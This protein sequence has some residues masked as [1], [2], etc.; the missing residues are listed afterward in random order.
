MPPDLVEC[1]SDHAYLGY[2]VGFYWLNQRLEVTS[3]LSEARDSSGYAFKV[4][5]QEFGCFDLIYDSSTDHWSVQ[6]P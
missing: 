6:Q 4:I 5:N 3:I 2:P 1:R